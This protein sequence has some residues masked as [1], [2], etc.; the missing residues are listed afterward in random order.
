MS[1]FPG[2]TPLPV[3]AGEATLE[4]F[5]FN[6]CHW[7]HEIRAVHWT[8]GPINLVYLASRGWVVVCVEGL[9]EGWWGGRQGT[10]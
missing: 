8:T 10:K 5:M 4:A 7:T 2:H 1:G 3:N 6:L 9:G